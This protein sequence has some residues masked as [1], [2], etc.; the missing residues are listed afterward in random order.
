[1]R[2]GDPAF[3]SGP[4]PLELFAAALFAQKKPAMLW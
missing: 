2:D 1:M 3:S 4:P